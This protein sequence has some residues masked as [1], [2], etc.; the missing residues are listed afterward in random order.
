MPKTG[1][2]ACSDT[3]ILRVNHKIQPTKIVFGE[4]E[5]AVALFHVNGYQVPYV[6][7]SRLSPALTSR[8]R[9]PVPHEVPPLPHIPAYYTTGTLCTMCQ[10]PGRVAGLINV[11]CL[12]Y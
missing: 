11:I 6:P 1:C 12:A 7:V 9:Q 3:G 4:G 5:V 8:K 2:S 10:V